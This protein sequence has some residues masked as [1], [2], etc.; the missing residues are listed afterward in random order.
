MWQFATDQEWN[1][2]TGGVQKVATKSRWLE[3][4]QTKANEQLFN[5]NWA[6]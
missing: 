1:L 5:K 3:G 4:I 2:P 6:L